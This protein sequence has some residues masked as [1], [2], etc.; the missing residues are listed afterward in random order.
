[1]LVRFFWAVDPPSSRMP[2]ARG[3]YG[4]YG[5]PRFSPRRPCH[6]ESSDISLTY[7]P[8]RSRHPRTPPTPP[9]AAEIPPHAPHQECLS[10]GGQV[11]QRSSPQQT[12]T[13]QPAA[14]QITWT[15]QTQGLQQGGALTP[16]TPESSPCPLSPT[17]PVTFH[18]SVPIPRSVSRKKRSSVVVRQV[19]PLGAAVD[20]RAPPPTPSRQETRCATQRGPEGSRGCRS[21]RAMSSGT[22]PMAIGPV[23]GAAGGQL[24]RRAGL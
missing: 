17:R 24:H 3:H 13:F 15:T 1:M 19:G 2:G 14:C 5:R 22:G 12:K 4:M 16:P 20:R 18:C 9:T 8:P 11:M 6:G 7:A 21:R 23:H 10:T